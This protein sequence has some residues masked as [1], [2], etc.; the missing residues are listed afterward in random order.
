MAAYVTSLME[1]VKAKNP[2][3]PEFHQAVQEVAESL[4]LVLEKRPEYRSAKILERIIEPE[5]VI[6]FRVPW[7]ND[8]GEVQV[9]RGFRV[10]MNSAIGPYKGGLRFHPSVTLGMLKFLAFEQVFKNALTTL[11]MGGGKGGSDFDPKGKS[12]GEVMRFTQSFMTELFRHI[13]PNTDVPAGDIGVG[14][15]EIGFLFGQYKRLANEFTGVLTGKGLNWGGSLIRPE[16]TGYGAVYFA[17]EMLATRGETLEGKVCLVSGSG[18]V[19]QFTV[20]KLLDFGA[21]PVTLSDSGGC[22]YDE[23]GIDR[24][25]LAFVMDLKNHRRGRIKEYAD[26]YKSAVFTPFDGSRDHDPLWDHKAQ[27]AFPSA[28]QNEINAK[29]A[30]NLL[31]NGVYVVSEGANMP[32]VPEGV[33]HFLDAKI[34]Y[35]PGKAAN[36]GG[37]ATSGLEMAQNSMRFAW[38]REEVDQKLHGIMKNIHARCVAVADEFGTP[39]NYV[40]GAN[41]AGFLKVADA[42]LDQGVV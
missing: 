24:E 19:A 33:E 39:G 3:E 6:L 30:K 23:A 35:G 40:N 36:A 9:N 37:V 7:V 14:G 28:T 38:S 5:R 13:G 20:E 25:K 11:P 17:A 21:K 32:T 42:M 15:R 27:C 31:K 8:R 4:E 18:N 34:L 1:D 12:D 22:I 26:K 41:I 29:D 16:A 10:E 2:A